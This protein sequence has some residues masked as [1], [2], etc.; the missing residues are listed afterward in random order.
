MTVPQ[1][2]R[3]EAG[4]KA[5][6][7]MEFIRDP[8]NYQPGNAGRG[9]SEGLLREALE[10]IASLPIMRG[11]PCGADGCSFSGILT[12][13]RA[14]LASESHPEAPE[15]ETPGCGSLHWTVEKWG[16]VT[17]KHSCPNRTDPFCQTHP[18]G[19]PEARSAS[20]AGLD[21]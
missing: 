8:E 15:T 9:A 13:V 20:V 7:W 10:D 4:V 1:S 6:D 12:I 16:R 19:C 14:A 17:H 2:P 21:E 5:L 3:T 11:E 18:D